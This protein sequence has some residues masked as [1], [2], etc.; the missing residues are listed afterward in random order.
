MHAA[1]AAADC[2]RN[3]RKLTVPGWQMRNVHSAST[4]WISTRHFSPSAVCVCVCVGALQA[5]NSVKALKGGE[6]I[7]RHL[8]SRCRKN[9]SASAPS[10]I[11]LI[12]G[13][14]QPASDTERRGD[15]EYSSLSAV[16]AEAGIQFFF[17]L[18]PSPT[19]RKSQ[20]KK[21]SKERNSKCCWRGHY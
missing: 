19:F 16:T 8:P 15:D 13:V 5:I 4:L 20:A 1:A 7:K 14:A 2:I 6:N 18:V 12:T 3:G 21:K 17:S 9:R 11:Q 10:V